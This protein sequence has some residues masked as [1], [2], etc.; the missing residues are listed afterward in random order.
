MVLPVP[1]CKDPS[2][3]KDGLALVVCLYLPNHVHCCVGE[4][5]GRRDMERRE[6]RGA[7]G[8]RAIRVTV[9]VEVHITQCTVQT[10][11]LTHD[12]GAKN[13]PLLLRQLA[14]SV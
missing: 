9:A 1:I 8:L 2:L 5:A 12:E 3:E 14:V 13:L 11:L 4:A 7:Q 10:R 6:R